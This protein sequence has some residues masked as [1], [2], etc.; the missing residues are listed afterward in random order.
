MISVIIPIIRPK[1]AERCMSALMADKTAPVFELVTEQDRERIGCPKMVKRLVDRT[2]FDRVC[3]LGDD[4]IPQ[5][6]MLKEAAD[7]MN[8]LPDGWGLVGI[9]DG[10]HQAR[11]HGPVTHWLAH[12]KLLPVLGGAFFHTGYTHC[13][14]DNELADRCRS[15]GRYVYAEKARLI[16]DHPI[17]NPEADDADYRRVYLPAVYTRDLRLYRKR[18]RN[19]WMM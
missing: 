4:T 8:T 14:C 10:I 1:K 6:G 2:R 19:A 18:R 3:F 13:F 15:L 5:P 11:N 9:N 12:K 17:I 16:H 7:T